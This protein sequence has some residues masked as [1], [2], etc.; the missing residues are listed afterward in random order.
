[1]NDVLADAPTWNSGT[2]LVGRFRSTFNEEDLEIDPKTIL[3]AG[4]SDGEVTMELSRR[5]PRTVILGLELREDRLP[6][7]RVIYNNGGTVIFRQGNFYMI[8]RLVPS[9]TFDAIFAMNNLLLEDRL[10][11]EQH[12]AIARN[13]NFV[14]SDGG[15]LFL[16]DSF[17]YIVLCKDGN[18]F[19]RISSRERFRMRSTYAKLA[20]AYGI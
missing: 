10:T 15:Y 20:E 14:L 6:D 13:L 4:C 8:D 7:K 19:E 18:G 11:L 2:C 9:E 16:T 17:D 3:D 1:M 5:Y 12:R